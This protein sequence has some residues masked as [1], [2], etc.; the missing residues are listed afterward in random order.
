MKFLRCKVISP[1]NLPEGTVL[2]LT[3]DQWERRRH[4]VQ[5]AEGAKAPVDKKGYSICTVLQPV[6]FKLG[7][8]VHIE[9]TAMKAK[10][11]RQF[12]EDQDAPPP[13]EDSPNQS[14]P[15]PAGDSQAQ[16]SQGGPSDSSENAGDSA[17]EGELPEGYEE[18]AAQYQ[19][20]KW[21]KL[22]AEVESRGGVWND[23]ADA[24]DFLA[25]DDLARAAEEA[26]EQQEEARE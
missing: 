20:W 4:V 3:Y 8:Q 23:E 5:L 25:K 22:K 17:D 12:Y 11:I 10:A 26:G 15:A 7:E 9:E 19:G 21:K 1:H 16:D 14:A 18:A 13:K 2:K 24:I 6:I